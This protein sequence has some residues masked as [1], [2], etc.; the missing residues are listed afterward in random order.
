MDEN[1]VE[2]VKAK[3]KIEDVI[4]AEYPFDKKRGRWWSTS[5]HDSL[6]VDVY[7]QCY[8]WN[9]KGEK[10]DVI[11]WVMNRQGCDF[12][13]AIEILCRRAGLPAP[14]WRREDTA[15]RLAARA[16]GDAFTVAAEVMH[17]WLMA[18]ADALAY[19]REGR[20]WET[21]T[22]EGGVIGWSGNAERRQ[23]LV[24]EMQRSLLAANVDVEGAAAVALTGFRGDVAGWARRAGVTV[25]ADW[26]ARGWIP[27]LIGMDMLVYPHIRFG[28][29]TYLSGRGVHEKRHYNLPAALAGERQVYMNF[30]W[31]PMEERCVIVEGQA[32]ALTLGQ[33]GIPAIA[34]AGVAVGNDF[35][36][37]VKR[38][39]YI[40]VGM[41]ADKA[42]RI[43]GEKV[44]RELGPMVRVM[45]WSADGQHNRYRSGGGEEREVKDANDYLR[46]MTT[47][48]L[49]G[50]DQKE[51][52]NRLLLN[53]LTYAEAVCMQAGEIEG[54][55]RDKAV[56]EAL[57]VVSRMDDITR[58]QYRSKLARSLGLQQR[59]YDQILK[60]VMSNGKKAADDPNEVVEIVGG[61]IQEHL[62]EMLYD[63]D[64]IAT[65]L[66]VR[67]PDGNVETVERLDID[68]VRYVPMAATPLIT[69][70]VVLF[71][72]EL[73]TCRPTR[74]LVGII[75]A[76]VHRYLDVDPFYERLAS[77]YVLFTWVYDS[78]TMVPYLRALGDYGTGKTRFI[79]T[80]GYLCYRPIL[81]AGATSTSSIFRLLDTYRGTLILDEADFGKSDETAD[82]IKIL[83]IGNRKGG[84]VLRAM[85]VGGGNFQPVPYTVF[86]PKVIAT[87]KKFGDQATES[88]CLTKLTGGGVPREDIPIVEPKEFWSQALEIRNL[89]L[90]YR[91]KHWVPEIEVDYNVADRA[92]EPRLN[93]VTLAL[94]AIIDDEELKG[95]I[96]EFIRRYNQQLIVERSM[97]PEAKVLEAIV[98]ISKEQPGLDGNVDLS[99]KHIRDKANE[100]INAENADDDEEEEDGKGKGSGPSRKLTSKGVGRYIR[101]K[102]QLETERK[103]DGYYLVWNHER[104]AALKRRYGITE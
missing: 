20:G 4:E 97:T 9:S 37:L 71:P 25:P 90:A 96:D 52:V 33:W 1:I 28:R 54:P 19:A 50:E 103:R 102:L 13:T 48:G 60:V 27:G 81:T 76:F 53:C 77:Y 38:H 31:S 55:E 35:V 44:S 3:C 32:D 16:R 65:K 79:E 42:G 88:R 92:I 69:R 100:I 34:L 83:N 39:Q 85:D 2:L 29:A 57:G 86:G 36:D 91:L 17:G 66:A 7:N 94:K 84:N 22:L 58:A 45:V 15:T 14:N 67:Y 40:Y 46:A 93:Q 75:Q 56:R 23:D 74:E 61:Y 59:E 6:V 98:A 64:Q 51:R 21:S 101:E 43:A 99:F 26:V 72:S 80:I 18:D 30:E 62:I 12:K 5:R 95:E 89:L 24:N 70:G 63:P 78:F 41:D 104:I 87:R 49:S 10:G 73:R 68:G 11:S 47:A 8:Y 82:V